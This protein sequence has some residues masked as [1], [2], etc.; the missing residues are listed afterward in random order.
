MSLTGLLHLEVHPVLIAVGKTETDRHTIKMWI[1]WGLLVQSF[2]RWK[3]KTCLLLLMNKAGFHNQR[4]D[5]F[6]ENKYNK[7]KPNKHSGLDWAESLEGKSHCIWKTANCTVHAIGHVVND[8]CMSKD[9]L[10]AQSDHGWMKTCPPTLRPL[11]EDRWDLRDKMGLRGGLPPTSG[12]CLTGRKTRGN[13]TIIYNNNWVSRLHYELNTQAQR[14]VT[15][16]KMSPNMPIPLIIH[17]NIEQ[18][19]LHE[20]HTNSR[21]FSAVHK[22]SP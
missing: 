20:Q 10:P 5:H 13:T 16:C 21:M 17:L 8:V 7:A 4:C 11:I 2:W 3:T 12:S 9:F 22:S 6:L 1:L 14:P 15:C 18:Y 19:N